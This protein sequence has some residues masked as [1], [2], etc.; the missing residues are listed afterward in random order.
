MHYFQP[1]FSKVKSARVVL[2]IF[3]LTMGARIWN[4]MIDQN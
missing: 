4:A 3:E 2:V 1:Q